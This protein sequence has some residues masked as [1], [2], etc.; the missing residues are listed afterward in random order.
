MEITARNTVAHQALALID[1]IPSCIVSQPA[2]GVRN[3]KPVI[4]AQTVRVRG[5]NGSLASSVGSLMAFLIRM[6]ENAHDNAAN[7]IRRFPTILSSAGKLTFGEY[8]NRM[9]PPETP[10]PSP[11]A[12]RAV[13]FSDNR[14][15]ASNAV[16]K[17][18]NVIINEASPAAVYF[19]PNMKKAWYVAVEKKPIK[20]ASLHC[21]LVGIFSKPIIFNQIRKQ[22]MAM[23]YLSQAPV[24]GGISRA[25]IRPA[26]QLAP[27]IAATNSSLR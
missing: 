21:P 19:I 25:M 3:T 10:S 5:L 4:E 14:G 17:G 15:I 27:Q 12:R 6:L 9:T 20:K 16:N 8:R 11:V 22:M 13:I 7:A 18:L 24:I 1:G 23:R 26:V 2:H